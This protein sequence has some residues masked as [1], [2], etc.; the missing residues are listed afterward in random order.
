MIRETNIA[1]DELLNSTKRTQAAINACFYRV[2]EFDPEEF[3]KLHTA[4]EQQEDEAPAAPVAKI[5]ERQH[6]LTSASSSTSGWAEEE[7]RALMIAVAQ[8]GIGR[9]TKIRED[10]HFTQSSAQ[11]SQR[12]VVSFGASLV[13]SYF[14]FSQVCAFSSQSNAKD[15]QSR[16]C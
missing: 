6:S 15:W 16:Q 10:L 8:H 4:V 2:P 14:S 11:M 1:T 13:G 9:W 5:P 12:C 7:D 3:A